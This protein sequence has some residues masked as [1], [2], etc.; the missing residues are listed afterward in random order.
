MAYIDS[1]FNKIKTDLTAI[2]RGKEIPIKV[3]KMPF[4]PNRYY[5]IE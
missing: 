4:V 5:K 2:V 1:P 3:A